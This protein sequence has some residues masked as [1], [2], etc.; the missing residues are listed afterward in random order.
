[1][2]NH[3]ELKKEEKWKKQNQKNQKNNNEERIWKPFRSEK[4][5]QNNYLLEK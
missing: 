2:K 4:F 1:M 3:I 5:A